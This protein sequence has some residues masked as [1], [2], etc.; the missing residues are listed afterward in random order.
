[1]QAGPN[2]K[3]GKEMDDDSD[4][5]RELKSGKKPWWKIWRRKLGTPDYYKLE[6]EIDA[7]LEGLYLK[8]KKS[9]QPLGKVIDDYLEFKLKF[10]KLSFKQ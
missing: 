7:N 3:K 4:S 9:R 8:A 2:V 10:P 1:M 5:R 6:K